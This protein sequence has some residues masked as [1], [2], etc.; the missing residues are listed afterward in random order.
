MKENADNVSAEK[1]HMI[2]VVHLSKHFGDLV[3][4]DDISD[5]VYEGERSASSGLRA[6]ARAR[7]SAV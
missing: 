5:T 6:A 4:L 3:V 1:K 2:D 7:I